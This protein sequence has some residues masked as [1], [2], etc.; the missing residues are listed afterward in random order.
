MKELMFM[1][2]AAWLA[3]LLA[4][5]FFPF[6]TFKHYLD[7]APY[8]KPKFIPK[9]ISQTFLNCPK[10]LAIWLALPA[11]YFPNEIYINISII[12]LTSLIASIQEKYLA[13]Y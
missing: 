8:D 7:L 1:L 10:C 11:L 3:N 4:W 12:L 5:G 2:A 6:Q 13:P 9:Q